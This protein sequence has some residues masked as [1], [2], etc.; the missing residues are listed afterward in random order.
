MKHAF[1]IG[2]GFSVPYGL[3][4]VEDINQ[5]FVSL[6]VDD[7]AIHS[8]RVAY[9]LKGQKDLNGWMNKTEREF[10]VEFVAFYTQQLEW[11]KTFHYEDFYDFYYRAYRRGER[12]LIDDFCNGFRAS[13][14]AMGGR[15][16]DNTNLLA[17]F[18]NSFVQLLEGQLQ[19]KEFYAIGIHSFNNHNYAGFMQFMRHLAE[20]GDIVDLHTLNHDLLMEH[21]GRHGF[22][23]YFSDGYYLEGSKYYGQVK[24]NKPIMRQYKVKLKQFHNK[25]DKP[26]RLY[27][28][29]GSVDTYIYDLSNPN[30]DR[31]RIKRSYGVQEIYREDCDP[32]T[33]EYSFHRGWQMDYADFLSG[34]TEKILQYKEEHYQVLFNHFE[35][36]LKDADNLIIIGYGFWDDGINQYIEEHFLNKGKVP[37]VIDPYKSTSPFY[38]AN[39]FMHIQKDFR[40]VHFADYQ[41]MI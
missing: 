36:N 13:K 40:D 9:P 12:N 37:V 18:H 8:S 14:E 17:D 41:K 5:F 31:T 11:G 7:F 21:V 1:L 38:L 20:K 22:W 25:Y 34:T 29:H 32:E 2:S 3:P 16:R 19:R 39:S 4:K 23:Q 24:V 30:I 35:R 15:V 33:S 26:I 28:L 27:K 10:F 6:K